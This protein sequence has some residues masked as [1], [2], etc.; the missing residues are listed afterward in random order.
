MI[1]W[2]EWEDTYLP[3]T[4]L[5]MAGAAHAAIMAPSKAEPERICF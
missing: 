3:T 4:P 5:A 1:S 2:D